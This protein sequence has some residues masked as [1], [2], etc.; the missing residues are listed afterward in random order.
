MNN[1][2][3]DNNGSFCVNNTTII[4]DCNSIR[5]NGNTINGNCNSVYGNGNTVQGDS[6]SLSGNGNTVFGDNT[7]LMGD[8]NT[9]YGSNNSAKGEGNQVKTSNNPKQINRPTTGGGP[10]IGKFVMNNSNIGGLCLQANNMTTSFRDGV[11]TSVVQNGTLS[12]GIHSIPV[13]GTYVRYP[14]GRVTINGIEVDWQAI[15]KE[16]EKKSLLPEEMK[17][18]PVI[19]DGEKE[20]V[21]CFGRS[22]KTVIVDCGHAVLCVTCARENIRECPICRKE[23]TQIIR[24]FNQ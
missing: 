18:E 21:V 2:I 6:T 11:H 15:A 22:I 20:C 13:N 14:S 8:G 16:K 17:N 7:S 19:V 5:G 24:T 23:V 10:L 1:T 4:G 12:N 3:R 9:L